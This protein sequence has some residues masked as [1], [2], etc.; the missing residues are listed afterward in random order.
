VAGV[1]T[2]PSAAEPLA[3]HADPPSGAHCPELSAEQKRDDGGVHVL[4]WSARG[5][6]LLREQ[7]L[8]LLE[9]D[10]AGNAA[11]PARLLGPGDAAPALAH[12]GA[13]TANGRYLA[14]VTP[15]G[16]AILDRTQGKTRVLAAPDGNGTISDVALSPSGRKL[17]L[18]RGRQVLI[19]EPREAPATPAP[20]G[21]DAPH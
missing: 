18:L 7:A 15:L 12:S 11:E 13:L 17:A 10:A 6:L 3:V 5:V 20:S 14:Q 9:L 2:G 21:G 8:F 1:V 16:V 19:G 4:D